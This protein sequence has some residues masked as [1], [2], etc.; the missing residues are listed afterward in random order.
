MGQPK[1]DRDAVKL[2]GRYPA[3]VLEDP[4]PIAQ[5]FAHS[6]ESRHATLRPTESRDASRPS[7]PQPRT[8]EASAFRSRWLFAGFALAALVPSVVLGALWLGLIGMTPSTPAV[9]VP[10]PR[11]EAPSPVLTAPDR[12]EAIA[13]EAVS[14]P[15][16][17]DGT[18]GMP[19]RSVIAITGLPQGSNLSEG[20]PYG[21]R[22][23]NLKPDQIGDLHLV[24]PA[25]A[26]GVF[27]VGTALVAPD[28]KVIAEAETQLE[29]ASA[30]AVP[31]PPESGVSLVNGGEAAVE[32]T[33]APETE[34]GAVAEP[35]EMG[36]A[37]TAAPS[38]TTSPEAAGPTA[39]AVVALPDADPSNTAQ[40]TEGGES[41]LGS[42]QPSVFVNLRERPSSSSAVIGVIAKG[43]TLTA[44]DRKRGWVQVVDPETAKKGWIYSGNLAGEA[45]TSHRRRRAAPTEAAPESD[46]IWS[47]FG[48]WLSPS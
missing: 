6:A 1:V 35:E 36:A 16:T 38:E 7:S 4:K 42:V 28:D 48:R 45:K 33:S 5:R 40:Q 10:E 15:I 11:G 14:F 19:S 39:E 27:K 30:T 20:R 12:I 31:P 25:D 13:G 3:G 24:P 37:A 47:R 46:S 26:K 44:L 29:I 2:S 32:P 43:V 8:R 34:I 41:G 17:L 21:D 23:W 9:P 18:D 22:E